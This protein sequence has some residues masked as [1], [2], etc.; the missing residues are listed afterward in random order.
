MGLPSETAA[1]FVVSHDRRGL[2]MNAEA[3]TLISRLGLEPLPGE[4]GFFART[5]TASSPSGR[6]SGRPSGSA[7]YFLITPEAFSG[8]HRLR[9]DE[10]WHYH[11]GDPAELAMLD[12]DTRETRL[13]L[14]GP[15]VLAG[16]EPQVVVYGGVWQGAR[17]R[18]GPGAMR[19]WTLFGCTL[20]PAWD[21][22]DFELGRAEVLLEQFPGAADWIRALARA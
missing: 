9:H 8:F 20:A 12:P 4:G 3:R 17:I 10:L 16:H 2:E 21:A 19:G 22:S 15:D 7:I 1:C 5:W 18:P 14:L 11:A 13:A 6:P